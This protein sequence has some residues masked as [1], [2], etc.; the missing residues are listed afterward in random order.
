MAQF[1]RFASKPLGYI[2]KYYHFYHISVM[3][4]GNIK[5]KLASCYLEQKIPAAG[6]NPASDGLECY[7]GMAEQVVSG[8]NARGY[9]GAII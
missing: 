1:H 4:V 2:C 3:A 8:I 6:L 9:A 5:L 7:A